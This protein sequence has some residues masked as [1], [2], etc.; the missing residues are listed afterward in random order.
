M[1]ALR[2]LSFC[3]SAVAALVRLIP[4]FVIFFI[5]GTERGTVRT[6]YPEV[7]AEALVIN[8]TKERT[9]RDYD[10]RSVVPLRRRRG[11]RRLAPVCVQHQQKFD[12]LDKTIE[13]WEKKRQ[14]EQPQNKEEEPGT[15]VTRGW[16]WTK[17]IMNT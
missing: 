10:R 7:L 9:H 12:E 13:S 15:S 16:M 6:T 4:A 8:G 17:Q 2:V 14:R 11:N 1:R 3:V 5:L